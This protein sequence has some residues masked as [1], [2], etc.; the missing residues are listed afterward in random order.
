MSKA[1]E[2]LV[3]AILTGEPP[4]I[5]NEMARE[6]IDKK[7][8]K[9]LKRRQGDWMAC[10][11]F[12][13]ADSGQS[14]EEMNLEEFGQDDHADLTREINESVEILN[15]R[16]GGLHYNALPKIH[17]SLTNAGF[18]HVQSNNRIHHYHNDVSGH[19]AYGIH[20]V[21]SWA[22]YKLR[23]RSGKIVTGRHYKHLQK[24]L[25]KNLGAAGG[26]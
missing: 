16:S 24:H 3:D 22:G 13:V 19:R 6:A 7:V 4:G 15:E 10:E 5:I 2:R 26:T 21:A 1:A 18:K 11:D 25:V 20:V 9:A 12:P 17:R 8:R 14:E 23:L